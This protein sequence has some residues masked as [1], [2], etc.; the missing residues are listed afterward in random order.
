MNVR[1]QLAIL[2]A[3]EAEFIVVG[4]QA[5][6]L[7]QVIEFSHDLDVLIR[8]TQDNAERVRKAVRE[9]S[10]QDPDV[11]LLLGRDFQQYISHGGRL[12]ALLARIPLLLPET[13]YRVRYLP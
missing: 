11:G 7:R 6:V 5:G 9:I 13:G 2:L 1:E 3:H 8:A 4:G 12:A 10:G